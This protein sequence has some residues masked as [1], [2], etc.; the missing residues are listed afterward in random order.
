MYI[1]DKIGQNISEG[2]YIVYGHLLGRCAALKIGLVLK[3]N[4][5]ISKYSDYHIGVIGIEE[6][7]LWQYDVTIPCLTKQG[8][9]QYPDRTLVLS[10]E[11]VPKEYLELFDEYQRLG[12]NYHFPTY[13]ELIAKFQLKQN[14]NN[15]Q[16]SR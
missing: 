8:T 9:I 13:D 3:I 2:S 11:I 15:T 1:K 12:K 10:R 4:S 16:T 14:E 5:V 6:K 7:H